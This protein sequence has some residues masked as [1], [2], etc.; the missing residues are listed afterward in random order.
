MHDLMSAS[1]IRIETWDVDRFQNC[2][3]D[4]TTLLEKSSSDPLFLSWE[5]QYTWWQV[6]ADPEHMQLLLLAARDAHNNLVGIAPLYSS[7]TV[8]KGLIKTRRIEFIGGC[9]RGRATM[10]TELLEFITDPNTTKDVIRAFYAHLSNAK[11]WDEIVLSNLK[12]GSPTYQL[13]VNEN[14]VSSAHYRHAEE[15]DSFYVDTRGSFESYLG[16]LGSN[17]RLKL[18]NRRKVFEQCGVIRYARKERSVSDYFSLLDKLHEQR[19]H[20][21]AFRGAPRQFNETLALL[22]QQRDCLDF[23]TL[24]VND[25]VVSIQYNYT[26][27]GH[28][29][30]IQAGFIE[31]YHKK[32]ALGYLHFGYEIENACANDVFKYD[33]LAGEGK[34][35]S[36]KEHLTEHR[37]RIVELQIIRHPLLKCLYK[38]HTLLKRNHE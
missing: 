7:T 38:L 34:N 35:T 16:Q 26:I 23:S 13:L 12:K 20:K 27:N 28:R 1:Q 17:T 11:Q 2:R 15:Y 22:M 21:A 4:W 32:L 31:D 19:W 6:F 25:E 36:Y 29:Y 30:N 18:F 5:W 10:R 24:E 33:M 37:E 8:T 3:S 14:L 9:W